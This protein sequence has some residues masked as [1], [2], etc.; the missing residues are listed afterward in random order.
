MLE[1]PDQTWSYGTTDASGNYRMKFNS[2]IEGVKPGEKIL[3][4]STTASTGEVDEFEE[5]ENGVRRTRKNELVPNVYYKESKLKVNITPETR[6]LNFDLKSD[7]ST[8]GP[9]E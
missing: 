7:G 9:T 5:D 4:V 6:E 2:E 3:R 1:A 8:K